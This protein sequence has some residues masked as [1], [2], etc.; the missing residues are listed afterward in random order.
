MAFFLSGH[1]T[2]AGWSRMASFTYLGPQPRWQR[3]GGAPG[4][5][6]PRCLSSFYRKPGLVLMEHVELLARESKLH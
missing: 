2:G 1:V 4:P 3:V 5:P 6:L